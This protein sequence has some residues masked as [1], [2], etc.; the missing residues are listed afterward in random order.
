MTVW[1]SVEIGEITPNAIR[2]QQVDGSI[3]PAGSRDVKG[4]RR[5]RDPFLVQATCF[6]F[7]EYFVLQ[8]E[9]PTGSREFG[10]MVGYIDRVDAVV[11]QA[12]NKRSIEIV[13]VGW[14]DLF[15]SLT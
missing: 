15:R 2:N 4:L 1:H 13:R 11:E 3:P 7:V 9:S 10:P 12:T 5:F 14:R 8:L 6:R